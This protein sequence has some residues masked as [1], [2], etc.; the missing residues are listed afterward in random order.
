LPEEQQ[1]ALRRV[2]FEQ[3]ERLR[4]LVEQLLDLSRLEAAAIEIRPQPLPVHR[5]VTEIAETAAADQP[6]PIRLDVPS[7]LV[8]RVDPAAG[9]HPRRERHHVRAALPSPAAPGARRDG[10]AAHPDDAEGI[11]AAA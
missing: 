9:E 3:A 5:R 7:D 11:A 8:A 1:T 4:A 2:L 10:A 6:A